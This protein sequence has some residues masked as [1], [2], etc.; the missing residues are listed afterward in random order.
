MNLARPSKWRSKLPSKSFE[1]ILITFKFAFF[2]RVQDFLS[3]FHFICHKFLKVQDFLPFCLFSR[4][5]LL[6]NLF[7]ER[8]D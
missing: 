4:P 3:F 8:W 5:F 1:E 7:C 2:F 6:F